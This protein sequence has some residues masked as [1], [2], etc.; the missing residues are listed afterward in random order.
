LIT[1]RWRSATRADSIGRLIADRHYNRQAVG[2]PQFVPP[3]RCVVLVTTCRRAYWITAWPFGEYV[4]H[5]WPGAWL[6]SAFRNEGAGLSSELIT[7]AIAAT[8]WTWPEVPDLGMITF[9]DPTKVRHKRD[10]GR[11]FRRAGFKPCGMTKSGLH[12]L[13]ILPDAMP[14]PAA[15]FGVTLN[16]QFE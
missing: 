10:F 3:G 4:K 13:Q 15:P 14:T 9:V 16:L 8:R 2:S 6:C 1:M 11:C 5:A 7:E 12:A